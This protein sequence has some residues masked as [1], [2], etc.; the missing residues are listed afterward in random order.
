MNEVALISGPREMK[1]TRTAV[2]V[3]QKHFSLTHL[4]TPHL[5]ASIFVTGRK[6]AGGKIRRREYEAKQDEAM[7]GLARPCRRT[8]PS[9]YVS[10]IGIC[11]SAVDRVH[12]EVV[13]VF[14]LQTGGDSKCR[15]TIGVA[16][17][18]VNG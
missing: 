10:W 16:R 9:F 11:S 13:V 6:I 2:P 17:L 12:A 1:T 3:K 8:Q 4:S 18:A 14:L 5:P 15:Q 7:L